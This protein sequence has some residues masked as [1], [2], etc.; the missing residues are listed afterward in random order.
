MDRQICGACSDGAGWVG[1]RRSSGQSFF[2][3]LDGSCILFSRAVLVVDEEDH[4]H[5]E[6]AGMISLGDG[7]EEE[8]EGQEMILLLRMILILSPR[9]ERRRI[10]RLVRGMPHKQGA[11]SS[12]KDGDRGSGRVCWE[13]QRRDMWRGVEDRIKELDVLMIGHQDVLGDGSLGETWVRVRRGGAVVVV[14]DG[15]KAR[16]AP[17]RHLFRL[18][19]VM[20]ALGLDPPVGDR[21]GSIYVRIA[22]GILMIA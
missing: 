17:A 13:G 7:V 11:N 19:R 3:Y 4:R 9:R 10:A 8:V 2:W 1:K 21:L 6:W 5:Q 14:V 18:L 12:N 15:I 20:R 16:A 22:L